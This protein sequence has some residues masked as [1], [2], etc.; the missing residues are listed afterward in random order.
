MTE[1]LKLA[2]GIFCTQ[3]GQQDNKVYKNT[4]HNLVWISGLLY[5]NI[6]TSK[7]IS[8]YYSGLVSSGTSGSMAPPLFQ[9]LKYCITY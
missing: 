4:S 7:W 3:W 9:I 8:M 1:Q 5:D 6:K 2:A